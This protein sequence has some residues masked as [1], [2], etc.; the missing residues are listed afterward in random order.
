MLCLDLCFVLCFLR[1]VHGAVRSGPRAVTGL[2]WEMV[3]LGC[4]VCTQSFMQFIAL[5]VKF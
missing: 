5:M 2:A 4:R 3:T 1:T